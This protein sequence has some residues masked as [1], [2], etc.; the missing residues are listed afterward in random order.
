MTNKLFN[1]IDQAPFSGKFLIR[2]AV[3]E[4]VEAPNSKEKRRFGQLNAI[5][6]GM[7][8]AHAFQT[9][10]GYEL[11]SHTLERATN[12]GSTLDMAI[13]GVG[14]AYAAV[15][16][17]VAARQLDLIPRM[18]EVRSKKKQKF[19][20]REEELLAI[21]PPEPNLQP[22][23]TT[24]PTGEAFPARERGPI[25]TKRKR[26]MAIAAGLTLAGQAAFMGGVYINHQMDVPQS[27]MVVSH[28]IEQ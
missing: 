9:Y 19:E 23:D 3:Q 13:A 11:M 15:N 2:D 25:S 28:T 10:L 24:P 18:K 14:G 12:S 16:A 8:V 1:T 21:P 26:A 4:Y 20:A 7:A 22:I 27:D 17:V 5:L 6:G